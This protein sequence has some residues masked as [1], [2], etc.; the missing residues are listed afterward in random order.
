M[1]P[2]GEGVKG[3]GSSHSTHDS[4]YERQNMKEIVFLPGVK[5]EPGTSHMLGEH[6]ATKPHPGPAMVLSMR[7]DLKPIKS[8]SL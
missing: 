5:M 4:L 3:Q 1:R 2:T 6:S 7:Q 8:S